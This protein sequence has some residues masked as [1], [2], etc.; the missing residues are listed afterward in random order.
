MSVGFYR[1]LMAFD[2][3][4][5]SINTMRLSG[6][7]KNIIMSKN[8]DEIRVEIDLID[9]QLHD[10]LMR[11]AAIVSSVAA[12]KKKEGL[13]IVHPAREAKMMRRLLDRHSGVLPKSTIV[14]IWR[15]LISSVSLLQTGLSVAVADNNN[16]DMAKNYFG[17]VIPMIEV[18]G[19]KNAIASLAAGEASFAVV[20]WPDMEGQSPWWRCLFNQSGD[21]KLSIICALPYA[22]DADDKALVVSK[23]NFM[24]SD[25]DV[26]FIG[27]ELSSKISRDLIMAC[28]EKAGFSAL[29]L[30]KSGNLYLIEVVGYWD[31]SSDYVGELYKS[32]DDKCLYCRVMGGYPVVSA[33]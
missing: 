31:D 10:L 4:T 15:E 26:S 25:E 21:D 11:R 33:E 5:Y 13:Q 22:G 17:S 16:W 6:W 28:V 1:R 2:F 27:L 3:D 9:N 12:A 8:L 20:P 14:R 19:E 7:S 18:G 32:L 29:N 24:P 30:Y 23:I